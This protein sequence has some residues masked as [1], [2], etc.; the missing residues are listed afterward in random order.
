MRRT[1]RK[2]TWRSASCVSL[3]PASEHGTAGR[4]RNHGHRHVPTGMRI[5]ESVTNT[6]PEQKHALHDYWNKSSLRDPQLALT[7]KLIHRL[8]L[9]VATEHL[10]DSRSM[11]GKVGRDR[12]AS[13]IH[14]DELSNS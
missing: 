3:T 8:A 4:R 10:V 14:N 11:I 6:A 5:S 1:R 9:K 2:S 13:H 7:D 12:S